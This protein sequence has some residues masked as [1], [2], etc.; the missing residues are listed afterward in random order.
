[1]T[2]A[3][4]QGGMEKHKDTES[5][6]FL[7]SFAARVWFLAESWKRRL[8]EEKEQDQSGQNTDF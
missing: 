8:T 4:R 6:P 3:Y 5:S 2:I 1:M 7:R